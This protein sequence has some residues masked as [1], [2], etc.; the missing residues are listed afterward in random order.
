MAEH[1]GFFAIADAFPDRAALVDSRDDPVSYGELAARMNQ[2]ARGLAALDVGPG[3][4]VAVVMSNRAELIEAYGAA[5]QTGLTFVAVNWHLGE[6][7]IAYI[8]QDAGAKA[9]IV[10]AQFADSARAAADQ[11]SLPESSRF[12]VD[13]RAG[14]RPYAELL[15]GHSGDELAERRAG[16]IMFYTS[17]TTGRP[18]GVRK[19]FPETSPDEIELRT[20]IGVRGP[21]PLAPD[22]VWPADT[23]TLVGGP[24]YHAAPIASAV[25]ALDTGSLVILMGKWTPEGFLELVREHRVTHAS[26]VPT[27]F[28]RL[29]A[30]PD[31]LRAGADVSSLQFVMHAGAPCPIDVKRRMIA[32]WGPIITES[33]SSTEGAGTTVTAEEWLRKPGTVGRPSPGVEITIVDDDGNEC[34][35][36]APGLVYLTQTMWKFDYHN[37]ADKTAS[38]RRG[39]LFTVGDIG[40]LDEDGYLFLCDRQADI[41]I[42]GGVNIYPAEV[43]AAL[44][45]HPAVADAT[46]VGAPNDEWGE[47]VRAVVQPEVGVAAGPDLEAQLIDFCQERLAHYKCPRAIDFVESLGR[48]PNGK[49]PKRAIRDRY[50]EGRARKI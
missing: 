23:V 18:K 19:Q 25:M 36:G 34:A 24:C 2:V 48:D 42:S 32:W 21:L 14:F 39:D 31:D 37:D 5:M 45:E 38:N 20:G 13:D 3:D 11:V 30:L 4:T 9:L 47:E 27:M 40:Y 43:E 44:L 6:A 16:Q 7:E 50:W 10:E 41:V 22:D 35:P 28:H 29:L 17:G 12:S 15:D 49:L 1:A 33:Y 8:L 46:V 26:M